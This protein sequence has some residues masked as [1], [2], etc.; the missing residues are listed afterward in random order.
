MT[1]TVPVFTEPVSARKRR[2]SFKGTVGCATLVANLP[3]TSEQVAHKVGCAWKHVVA[4]AMSDMH[5]LGL[6]YRYA[7]IYNGPKRTACS[8]WAFG[9][10]ASVPL[11]ARRAEAKARPSTSAISFAALVRA[12]YAGPKS[13]ADLVR[14]TGLD[15][16]S[17]LRVLRVLKA[18]GLT[19]VAEWQ[20]RHG[21]P[22]PRYA[23]GRNMPD[24]AKP[25]ARRRVV[26]AQIGRVA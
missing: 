18:A 23:M 24:A 5:R 25:Q 11:P 6:V 16:G 19:H 20:R 8:V 3:A 26:A 13:T 21:A 10:S 2:L 22:I 14:E 7:V 17:V 1:Y 15:K 9:R 12:M 4:R